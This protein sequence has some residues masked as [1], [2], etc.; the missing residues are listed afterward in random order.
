MICSRYTNE[1]DPYEK[2]SRLSK[3]IKYSVV[4]SSSTQKWIYILILT[5]NIRLSIVIIHI[6]VGNMKPPKVELL[7]DILPTNDLIEGA[8]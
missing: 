7:D 4:T 2:A 6:Y 5:Y 3:R 8:V 1:E